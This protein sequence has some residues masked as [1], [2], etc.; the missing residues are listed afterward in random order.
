MNKDFVHSRK[1]KITILVIFLLILAVL[2]FQAGTFLGFNRASF[3]CQWGQNYNRNFL[4]ERGSPGGGLF[5]NN[6]IRPHGIFGTVIKVSDS[7]L[8]IK[9]RDGVEKIVKISDDADIKSG[10]DSVKISDIKVGDE[11]TIIGAPNSSA[12]IDAD[13]VRVMPTKV[14]PAISTST[15]LK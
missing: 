9:D 15:K 14:L 1:F 12:E 6:P 2:I 13:F 5:D 7:D 8:V 3:M 4:G 11:I 10:R